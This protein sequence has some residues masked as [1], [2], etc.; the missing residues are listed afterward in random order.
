[1]IDCSQTLLECI[2]YGSDVAE[3]YG[4]LVIEA[5]GQM[6]VDYH[7]EDIIVIDGGLVL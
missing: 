6:A 7:I 2:L 5:V 1:M 4:R 3:I